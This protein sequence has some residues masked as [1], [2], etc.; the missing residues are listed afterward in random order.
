MKSNEKYSKK[1][2]GV[3]HKKSGFSAK[4]KPGPMKEERW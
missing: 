2:K 1:M 3:E 4:E